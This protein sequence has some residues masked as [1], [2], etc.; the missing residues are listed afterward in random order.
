MSTLASIFSTPTLIHTPAFDILDPRVDML[1]P[2]V[3]TLNPR[4]NMEDAGS[5]D[6][7][8]FGGGLYGIVWILEEYCM[9]LYGFVWLRMASYG[10][11]GAWAV[12]LD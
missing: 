10:F 6:V 2:H 4:V 9:G 7:L 11:V 12:E 1:Y 3:N 5:L 8:D